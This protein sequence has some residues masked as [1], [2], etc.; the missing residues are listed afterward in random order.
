MD[1]NSYVTVWSRFPAGPHRERP[2]AW[3]QERSC[4]LHYAVNPHGWGLSVK[5][6]EPRKIA[7][8]GSREYAWFR[9]CDN[10]NTRRSP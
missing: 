1:K 8:D 10:P 3:V 5:E 7:G 9:D 2:G 6:G 4:A